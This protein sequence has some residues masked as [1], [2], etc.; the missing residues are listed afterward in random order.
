MS[1]VK[2]TEDHEWIRVEGDT[3][4]VGITDYAQEQLG[5][6]VYVELPEIGRKVEKGKDMAVVESVK[7]ASEVY[8]PV[9]GLFLL[10]GE[11]SRALGSDLDLLFLAFQH[12]LAPAPDPRMLDPKQYHVQV[13][14]VN[15][16]NLTGPVPALSALLTSPHYQAQ[17]KT[18]FRRVALAEFLPQSRRAAPTP[19]GTAGP[20][21][22]AT[23]CWRSRNCRARSPSSAPASSA[24]SMRRSSARSTPRSP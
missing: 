23:S 3:G 6:V 7:A 13:G 2:F 24:S 1:T 5:D 11:R 8:A 12:G 21:S 15:F 16:A 4:T 14:Y 20:S 19:S 18:G 9:T 22:T 10:D 17:P